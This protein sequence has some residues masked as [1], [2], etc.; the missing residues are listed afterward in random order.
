[1]WETLCSHRNAP[2]E[3]ELARIRSIAAEIE[4]KLSSHLEGNK[5]RATQVDSRK[6]KTAKRK[7]KRKRE[8]RQHYHEVLKEMEY[9]KGM[10]SSSLITMMNGNNGYCGVKLRDRKVKTSMKW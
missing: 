3:Q 2:K 5:D 1:M 6:K 7:K 8:E 4:K 9:I 10:S